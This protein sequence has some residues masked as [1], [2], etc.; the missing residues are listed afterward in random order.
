MLG[1]GG[2]GEFE[3]DPFAV[4]RL[5]LNSRIG[6]LAGARR[7]SLAHPGEPGC[8]GKASTRLVQRLHLVLKCAYLGAGRVDLSLSGGT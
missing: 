3:G 2:F 7:G 4:G 5:D 6:D 8:L 1:A